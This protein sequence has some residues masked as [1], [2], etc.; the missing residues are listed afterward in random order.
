MFRFRLQ[1]VLELREKAEQAQA[2]ELVKAEETA[3]VARKQ[4]DDL[5]AMRSASR[6]QLTSAHSSDPTVGHLHHIGFVLNALDERLE[7]ASES[8]SSAESAASGAR[9]LLEVAARDRRVMDRLKDKHEDE[10]R[11]QESHRDRVAMDEIA[12]ARFTRQREANRTSSAN[13]PV[14]TSTNAIAES[15]GTTSK[16][17]EGLAQA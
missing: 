8:L 9:S 2:I 3:S 13:A 14:S 17:H 4:R 10:H 16:T 11:A 12:L 7:H 5:Q 15:K 1:R 6:Q